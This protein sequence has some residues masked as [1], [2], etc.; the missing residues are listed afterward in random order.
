[1][2]IC[3]VT[4]DRRCTKEGTRLSERRETT[5]K[6]DSDGQPVGF[7]YTWWRGDPLPELEPLEGLLIESTEDTE[8]LS[9]LSGLNEEEITR[10]INDG[11]CPYVA[12]VN[13]EPVAYGWSAWKRAEIGELGVDMRLPE[14]NHYLWDFFTLPDWRGYGIYPLMLQEIIR[15]E[16][17]HTERFWIG[18]DLDNIASGKGIERAGFPVIGEVWL[19]DGEPVY[20]A[21]EPFERARVAARMLSLAMEAAE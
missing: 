5:S 6:P 14:G 1:M 8:L 18:H 3:E 7:F 21:R 2:R 15:R 20:V 4:A 13:G 11:H 9:D 19:R 16:V 10:R 12:F 17:G